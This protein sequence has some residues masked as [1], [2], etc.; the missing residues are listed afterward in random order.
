MDPDIVAYYDLGGES[1]RFDEPRGRLEFLRTR[2]V[3]MRV[4]PAA[5]AQVLDVGGATGAYAGWLAGRG[6][7][8]HVVDP[9]PAH[10]AAA[11]ALPGVDAS[12]GDARSLAAADASV[13]A[14]LLLGPIYHLVSRAERVRALAQARRVVRPG[15][16]VVAASISR[17]ASLH[18]GWVHGRLD[19]LE[20]AR[21]VRADLATGVHRN[22]ERVPGW[23]TTAYFHRPEELAAEV[24]E[25]GLA[26]VRL[27][28]VEGAHGW[29][30]P[31]PEA[32]PPDWPQLL[33]WL[34]LVE[35]EPSL[36][37]ASAHVLAVAHRPD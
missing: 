16:V 14:V 13:D 23:F 1:T 5:P 37:G 7:R 18:D 6:Y 26:G 35:E 22:P 28:G 30:A 2:D 34:R 33:D 21:T 31:F 4:L 19:D 25:A 8:V 27:V 29:M 11:A 32:D 10:V 9:V 15:G 36:V 20:F 3:L 24:A 12:V 17:F